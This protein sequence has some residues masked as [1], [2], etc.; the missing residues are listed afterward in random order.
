[1]LTRCNTECI[2]SYTTW[3][4]ELK[5]LQD[6]QT[7]TFKLAPVANNKVYVLSSSTV[8]RGLKTKNE[9][10]LLRVQ[11]WKKNAGFHVPQSSLLLYIHCLLSAE[12]EMAGSQ[13]QSFLLL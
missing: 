13:K 8:I 9:Y 7:I 11:S 5:S 6:M 4:Q 2:L 12:K 10:P 1:M 3:V